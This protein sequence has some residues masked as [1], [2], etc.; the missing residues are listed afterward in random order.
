MIGIDKT[1]YQHRG[2]ARKKILRASEGILSERYTF[3]LSSERAETTSLNI[4]LDM[5]EL[6]GKR[7]MN[8]RKFF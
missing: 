3:V 8:N 7:R 4:L 6:E 2:Q 1:V 5:N